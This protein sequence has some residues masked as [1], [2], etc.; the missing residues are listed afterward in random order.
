MTGSEN[1]YAG[2]LFFTLISLGAILKIDN[3]TGL[4]IGAG[5]AILAAISLRRALNQSAQ[6]AEEDHQRMEIQFQQL[7]SKIIETSS[8][9]IDAMN[10]LNDVARLLK[11]NLQIIHEQST[12]M[13]NLLN[14]LKNAESVNSSVASLEENSFA[15]NAALEKIFIAVQSQGKISDMTAELKNLAA[16]LEKIFVAVQ[17]P[18]KLSKVTDELKKFA[19]IEET[20]K[21]NLQNSLKNL[22]DLVQIMKTST[23]AEDIKKINSSIENLGAIGDNL[24]KEFM[25]ILEQ[26]GARD[27]AL[28]NFTTTFG[29]LNTKAD[30]LTLLKNS[31]DNTNKNLSS[32]IKINSNFSKNVT[33]TIDNLRFEVAKLSEKLET[34]GNPS[35]ENET[36]LTAEDLDVLKKIMA[37]INPK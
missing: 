21:A 16:M 33:T 27:D 19:A 35:K 8:A 32:L 14:L 1:S 3:F 31:A 20:N 25:M 23:C 22:N 5:T 11:E 13:D 36:P 4:M 26:I 15:L 2:A 10:S 18:E 29:Q 24:L 12:N 28:K 37:K 30:T 17:S 6:A 9:S 7:R 34:I